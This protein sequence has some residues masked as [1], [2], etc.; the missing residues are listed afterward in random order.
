MF[1]FIIYE[2]EN[3]NEDDNNQKQSETQKP[4]VNKRSKKQKVIK[5]E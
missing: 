2:S 1:H 5:Q 3:T 4:E